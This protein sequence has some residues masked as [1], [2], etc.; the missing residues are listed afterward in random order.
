M[1]AI[2]SILKAKPHKTYGDYFIFLATKLEQKAGSETAIWMLTLVANTGVDIRKELSPSG[3]EAVAAIATFKSLLLKLEARISYGDIPEAEILR[4]RSSIQEVQE[5]IRNIEAGPEK[6]TKETKV[7]PGTPVAAGL[8]GAVLV[9]RRSGTRS[10]ESCRDCSPPRY[11][12]RCVC[13]PLGCRSC[14]RLSCILHL[15]RQAWTHL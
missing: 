7:A 3:M 5:A 6:Q 15:A 9:Q 4:V 13:H 12:I 1:P 14:I 10:V 11:C 2:V 8:T